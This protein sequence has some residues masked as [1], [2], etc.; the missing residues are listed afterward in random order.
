VNNKFTCLTTAHVLTYWEFWG[1]YRG[2]VSSRG[3]LDCDAM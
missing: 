3:L 1:F 2:D